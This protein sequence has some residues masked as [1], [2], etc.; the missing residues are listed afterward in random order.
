MQDV[1]RSSARGGGIETLF[2]RKQINF[3]RIFNAL[4]QNLMTTTVEST[5]RNFYEGKVENFLTCLHLSG[6]LRGKL[7]NDVG[8]K[9][10]EEMSLNALCNSL[11]AR[12]S[13]ADIL[14]LID[15]IPTILTLNYPAVKEIRDA[16]IQIIPQLMTTYRRNNHWQGLTELEYIL[17]LLKAAS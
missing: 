13:I 10:F 1:T 3:P 17:K 8:A 6:Y 2:A 5:P 7:L 16:C 15:E 4:A 11:K 9:F 14:L 12:V